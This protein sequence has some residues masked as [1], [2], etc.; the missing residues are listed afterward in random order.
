VWISLDI[1]TILTDDTAAST[2]TTSGD[3]GLVSQ[4][5][6][7]SAPLL[8][9]DYV[10]KRQEDQAVRSAWL[11]SFSFSGENQLVDV[12]GKVLTS[13]TWRALTVH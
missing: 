8:L 7:S 2:M 5:R 11:R 4:T 10:P 9:Q 12:G 13:R 6:P 3:I 1:T